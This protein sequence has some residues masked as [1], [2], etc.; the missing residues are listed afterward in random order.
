MNYIYCDYGRN[1]RDGKGQTP[2]LHGKAGVCPL[3]ESL[4]QVPRSGAHESPSIMGF[5][6]PSWIV[7][8]ANRTLPFTQNNAFATLAAE[9][10]SHDSTVHINVHQQAFGLLSRR[11]AHGAPTKWK[12]DARK[13]A[14]STSR[15]SEPRGRG[16]SSYRQSRS[17]SLSAPGECSHGH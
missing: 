16:H 13:G 17:P 4:G 2:L 7:Q 14:V 3:P 15:V 9:D 6:H 8:M 1:G 5:S 11:H 12:D 10:F